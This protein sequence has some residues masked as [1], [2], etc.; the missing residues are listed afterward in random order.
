M[1]YIPIQFNAAIVHCCSISGDTK[2]YTVNIDQKYNIFL[3]EEIDL[4]IKN[5]KNNSVLPFSMLICSIN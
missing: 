2:I 5:D 1:R 4:N 3:L